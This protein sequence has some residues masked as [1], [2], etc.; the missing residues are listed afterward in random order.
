MAGEQVEQALLEARWAGGQ[1]V[2]REEGEWALLEVRQV[3]ERSGPH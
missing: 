2:A 1:E 3:S